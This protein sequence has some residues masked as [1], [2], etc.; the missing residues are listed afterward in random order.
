MRIYFVPTIWYQKDKTLRAKDVFDKDIA[1]CCFTGLS[2][3]LYIIKKHTFHKLVVFWV[4]HQRHITWDILVG[5]LVIMNCIRILKI[6]MHFANWDVP[7]SMSQI[8]DS[9]A[10]VSVTHAWFNNIQCYWQTCE[11]TIIFIFFPW[12]TD[13][14]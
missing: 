7:S 5:N 14:S 2:V 9:E 12:T 11:T 4:W 10:I 8:S 3:T 13:Q 6:W 1:Q